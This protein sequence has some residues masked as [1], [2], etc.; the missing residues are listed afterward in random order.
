M[1]KNAAARTRR[2]L[3]RMLG[4]WRS[5][6]RRPSARADCS[7]SGGVVQLG[8]AM[9]EQPPVPVQSLAYQG[10]ASD[11]W[12]MITRALATTAIALGVLQLAGSAAQIA[13]AFMQ[14]GP[15]HLSF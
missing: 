11:T 7:A 5:M 8:F 10:A 6:Q 12:T 13:Q 9:S 1:A 4:T 14:S 15:N 2:R 3:V